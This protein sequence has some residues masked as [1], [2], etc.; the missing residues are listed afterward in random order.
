MDLS[1]Q[2]EYSKNVLSCSVQG[3]I[4]MNRNGNLAIFFSYVCNGKNIK[5]LFAST[6]N[7]IAASVTCVSSTLAVLNARSPDWLWHTQTKDD[8]EKRRNTMPVTLFLKWNI[9]IKLQSQS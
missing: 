4:H 7:G 8:D 2:V 5:E 6:L 9:N 3:I 1:T